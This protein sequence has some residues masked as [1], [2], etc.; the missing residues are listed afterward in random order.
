MARLSR[1]AANSENQPELVSKEFDPDCVGV[2]LCALLFPAS[3]LFPNPGISRLAILMKLTIQSRTAD[4]L[5][6]LVEAALA[7][8]DQQEKLIEQLRQS[9]KDGDDAELKRLAILL[10]ET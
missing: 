4:D 7:I 2:F 8:A 3:C 6:G 1:L 5:T 10:C 9:L